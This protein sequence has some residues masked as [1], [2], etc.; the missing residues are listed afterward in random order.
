MPNNQLPRPNIPTPSQSG[1]K[2]GASMTGLPNVKPNSGSGSMPSGGSVPSGKVPSSGSVPSG[3]VTPGGVAAS[4][5]NV[6][7]GDSLTPPSTPPLNP[8]ISSIPGVTQPPSKLQ[9]PA[10]LDPSTPGGTPPQLNA[11]GQVVKASNISATRQPPNFEKI[12]T[13]PPT[14]TMQQFQ[15]RT[16]NQQPKPKTDLDTTPIVNKTNNSPQTQQPNA[17][18]IGQQKIQAT[19]SAQAQENQQTAGGIQ[20][21]RP[22]LNL[23][24][25]DGSI[26]NRPPIEAP[27]AKSAKPIKSGKKDKKS[28]AAGPKTAK[29]KSSLIKILPFVALGIAVI[30]LV[31]FGVMRII[32]SRAPGDD[33]SG[34]ATD[35][36]GSDGGQAVRPE[37]D[38]SL[39][40]WGLWEPTEVLSEV[41]ADFEQQ[42][43]IQVDYVKQS[44]VD[45]RTRLVNK[46]ASGDG[47]DVFRYHA[48]WVSMLSEE[49]SPMPVKIMSAT[50][51]EQTYYPIMVEQLQ[52]EGQIVG[53]PL[54]YDGLALYYNQDM[55]ETAN[56]EVP[57][58]WGD[59][60]QLAN[61]LTVRDG[62]EVTR[63]GL[64]IGNT[65]NVEHFADILGLLIYQNSGDP[66][67][68]ES[69]E[70][71]DAIKFYA[72]FS[73]SQPVYSSSLPNSTTAFAREEVA[74][75]FAPSWRAHEILAMN[76]DLNFG[77]APVPKLSDK[78]YGWASYWAEGV[79]SKGKNQDEAWELLEYL[80][81][82]EVL[83]KLYDEQS[84]LR[85]FGE[86][87]PRKD[88]ANDLTNE[89]VTAF[90]LDAPKAQGWSL[91]SFTHDKGLNDR[92]ISYYQ[93]ALNSAMSGNLSTTDLETL[94]QGV[95]HVLS[96]FG[97]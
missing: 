27:L 73:Q 41:L 84:Q 82:K 2:P 48:T 52:Y 58:T 7:S 94:S 32:G 54:M 57:V 85:A 5:T 35:S 23:P 16:L 40:Y 33:S 95:A 30:G 77:I 72:S 26:A 21:S 60:R 91:C 28:K 51:F 49:L 71:Q 68:P 88:M 70:V 25:K 19:P 86:I 63:G 61:K 20:R 8:G 38:T 92:L 90:L 9:I 47:P 53:L 17:H 4:D 12:M 37:S 31:I 1:S 87:Y 13:A 39:T 97:Q 3:R 89:Y 55:L 65:S 50:E 75:I 14:G 81:T 36:G 10:G 22:G 42:T 24:G 43:G 80:S 44:H 34:V 6:K 66:S 76:P 59:L 56:E 96:Q 15:A 18:V 29:P 83:K 78:G 79:N 11:Q 62:D 74:M 69:T 93:D 64:A 67:L 46:I 45:Y